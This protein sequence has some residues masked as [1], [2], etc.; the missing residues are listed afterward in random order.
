MLVH[1]HPS[2]AARYNLTAMLEHLKVQLQTWGL[3]P[4]RQCQEVVAAPCV[5][6]PEVM[7]SGYMTSIHTLIA[8]L[9]ES[10]TLI[11][12]CRASGLWSLVVAL[13]LRH[14]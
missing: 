1:I 6:D 9:L 5:S 7:V 13:V 12:C 14:A 8:A 4:Y 3:V 2:S 10:H 11:A